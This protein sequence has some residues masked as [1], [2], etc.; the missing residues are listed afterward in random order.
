MSRT[1][2]STTV[3]AADT[4]AVVLVQGELDLATAPELARALA[5]CLTE[6]YA[7]VEVDMRGVGFMACAGLNAL[8]EARR[9]AQ[10]V[11][12]RLEVVH[13]SRVV[14]RLLTLTATR[15][16]LRAGGLGATEPDAV[17]AG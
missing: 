11:G 17:P 10:L 14:D 12:V 15:E 2:F 13:P 1:S 8:L 5:T 3:I 9:A 6:R 4:T 7:A 16:L